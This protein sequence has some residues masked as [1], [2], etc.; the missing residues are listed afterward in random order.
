MIMTN[1][2]SISPPKELAATALN[3]RDVTEGFGQQQDI[4]GTL[5]DLTGV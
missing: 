2:T 3:V 5:I 1:F 4:N